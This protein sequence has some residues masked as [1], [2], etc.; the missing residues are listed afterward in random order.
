MPSPAAKSK[1]TANHTP[2]AA[3]AKQPSTAAAAKPT[4]AAAKQPTTAA[5]QPSTAAKPADAKQT[6]AKPS[7]DAKPADAKSADAKPADAKQT[8]AKPADAKP[9]DAKPADAKP[10]EDAKPTADSSLPRS[11]SFT[12]SPQIQ[13]VKPQEPVYQSYNNPPTLH[14]KNHKPNIDPENYCWEND[15]DN[16]IQLWHF[17]NIDEKT[18]KPIINSKPVVSVIQF[19][20]RNKNSIQFKQMFSSAGNL[21]I[22]DEH[23]SR[24]DIEA[25]DPRILWQVRDIIKKEYPDIHDKGSWW[26]WFVLQYIVNN[27]LFIVI[28][29]GCTILPSVISFYL[30]QKIFDMHVP[31]AYHNPLVESQE[32][33]PSENLT[34]EPSIKKGAPESDMFEEDKEEMKKRKKP[35]KGTQETPGKFNMNNAFATFIILNVLFTILLYTGASWLYGQFIPKCYNT[36]SI[37]GFHLLPNTPVIIKMDDLLLY[38]VGYNILLIVYFGL[39]KY[40]HVIDPSGSIGAAIMGLPAGMIPPPKSETISNDAFYNIMVFAQYLVGTVMTLYILKPLMVFWEQVKED[41]FPSEEKKL[42]LKLYTAMLEAKRNLDKKR[43]G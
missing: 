30:C 38:L 29:G 25:L 4:T 8:D 20:E 23:L 18:G 32:T 42:D 26:Y 35:E 31:D 2:P 11:N 41:R 19:I 7:T 15:I 28:F 43:Q 14:Q 10:A 17:T 27:V 33:S 13:G 39:C 3:A 36:F 6:A 40:H 9:A 22:E 5:K 37:K 34:D 21:N 12:P 1:I 16:D 24:D